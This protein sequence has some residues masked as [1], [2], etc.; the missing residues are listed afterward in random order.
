MW[1]A[2]SSVWCF[3][4][5]DRRCELWGAGKNAAC[6][7]LW[8]LVYSTLCCQRPCSAF[9]LGLSGSILDRVKLS[10]LPPSVSDWWKF[11][12]PRANLK[13]RPILQRDFIPKK[14]WFFKFETWI[15]KNDNLL[16]HFDLYAPEINPFSPGILWF[17]KNMN[18]LLSCV[19][20][21][22]TDRLLSITSKR[23]RCVYRSLTQTPKQNLFQSL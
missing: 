17:K 1:F 20:S 10:V 11:I 8:L 19:N 6:F 15:F 3:L 4:T 21:L 14:C 2:V 13:S 18:F 23:Q 9:Y 12:F 22:M 7:W 5:P 16:I